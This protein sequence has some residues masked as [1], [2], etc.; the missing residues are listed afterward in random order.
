MSCSKNQTCIWIQ[1]HLVPQKGKIQNVLH[2]LKDQQACKEADM[3]HD[4][5]KNQSLGGHDVGGWVGGWEVG[6][7]VGD[8]LKV[9]EQVP[10][11]QR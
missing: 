3:I 5:E 10:L 11:S 2:T 9:V 6:R 4:E 8:K 7:W 1:K